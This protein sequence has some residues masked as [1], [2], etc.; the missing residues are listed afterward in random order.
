M[1][2]VKSHSVIYLK[3]SYFHDIRLR[4]LVADVC[5][6]NSSHSLTDMTCLLLP[7]LRGGGARG[8]CR[9]GG[10]GGGVQAPV[11]VGPVEL[12]CHTHHGRQDN[13]G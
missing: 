5:F 8:V 2:M 3:K 13:H 9:A 6:T 4:V 1:V 12:S 11:P 10:G 7:E